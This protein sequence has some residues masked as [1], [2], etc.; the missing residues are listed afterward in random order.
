MSAVSCRIAPVFILVMCGSAVALSAQIP[1]GVSPGLVDRIVETGARCPTF[2]WQELPDASGYELVAYALP[3]GVEPAAVTSADLGREAEVLYARVPGGATSWTPA[4]DQCLAPDGSYVWFVRGIHENESG[5]ETPGD[6]SDGLFFAVSAVPSREEV[7]EA[8]RVLRRFVGEDVTAG[9]ERNEAAEATLRTTPTVS[10]GTAAARKSVPVAATAIRGHL[11]APAGEV[12][13]VVGVVESPDGAGL[14]A[15]NLAGGADLVLDGSSAGGLDLLLDESSLDLP[16]ASDQ[17]FRMRNTGGGMLNLEV[18]GVISG[19]GSGLSEVNAVALGGLGA[20]EYATD[21][22]LAASGGTPVHWDNLSNVPAD[23]AD[24]DQDTTYTAGP[25]LLLDGNELSTVWPG[26]QWG[27]HIASTIDSEGNVGYD[28]SITTGID[29]LGLIS[30]Y[31]ETNGDLKVVHC[32]D[33]V[34]S[35]ATTSTVD[36]TGDVGASSSITVGSDGLG[37]ISYYDYDAIDGDLKVA[38]CNDVVCSTATTSTIDSV[39][40]VGGFASITIGPDGLPLISY[41]DYTNGDLKVAHCNDIQCSS[42]TIAT[43]DSS[44]L[45]GTWNS[46]TIGS[47]R[48]G[49]ISYQDVVNL[50][51]KVAH[52]SDVQ[53]SSATITTID[54]SGDLAECTSITVGRDGLGIIS[55]TDETNDDLKVAHCNNVLCTSATTTT[56]DT[57]GYVGDFSSITIGPDGLGVI[58]YYRLDTGNLKVAHCNNVDCS[59]A[60]SNGVDSAGDVGFGTS[61]TTGADGLPLISYYDYANGDLKVVH[62]SNRFCIP[63][64]RYR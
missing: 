31:D 14:A 49:L 23:L 42:A 41:Y 20:D 44:G 7:A 21:G 30:Y 12:Y 53:C 57:A 63:N 40:N 61:I 59:Q 60:S 39:G 37:I 27:R 38:H 28:P 4:L 22:E 36:S 15:A 16:S 51:L 1:G 17:V 19:N 62:C 6:W 64:V 10:L 32:N 48:L 8:M 3:E 11:T 29:G 13:G 50:D 58:S 2:S 54:S 34:C 33:V 45:V 55:Y 52:C 47:D 43:I 5:E 46:I 26:T 18:E 25:G 35:T 24:G 56:I 9:V